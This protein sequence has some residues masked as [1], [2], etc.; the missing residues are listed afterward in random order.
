[1]HNH[2]LQESCSGSGRTA[3]FRLAQYPLDDRRS[4]VLR[5][6]KFHGRHGAGPLL[7]GDAGIDDVASVRVLA[8][9]GADLVHAFP[10]LSDRGRL[11]HIQYR[12]A[13]R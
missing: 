7:Q 12:C 3:P 11:P 10:R 9:A 2:G 5:A 1:V 13:P 8:L 4:N 6:Q